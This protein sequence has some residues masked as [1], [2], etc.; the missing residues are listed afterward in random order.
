MSHAI[1]VASVK[2]CSSSGYFLKL[3]LSCLSFVTNLNLPASRV[4]KEEARKEKNSVVGTH[5][6]WSCHSLDVRSAYHSENEYLR[7]EVSHCKKRASTSYVEA[8]RLNRGLSFLASQTVG[9]SYAEANCPVVFC[10]M[11]RFG[12]TLNFGRLDCFSHNFHDRE[13]EE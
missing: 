13:T 1:Y 11:P 9:R 8:N 2:N 12:T 7:R 3:S 5:E 10:T 4:S 6:D